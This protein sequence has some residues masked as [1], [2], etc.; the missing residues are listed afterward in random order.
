MTGQPV[1][2]SRKQPQTT[3]SETTFLNARFKDSKQ[4]KQNK[5]PQQT[6]KKYTNSSIAPWA[7]TNLNTSTLQTKQVTLT[8]ISYSQFALW[9]VKPIYMSAV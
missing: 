8:Y 3:S 9:A 2:T 6:I 5:K 7:T 1:K 4:E